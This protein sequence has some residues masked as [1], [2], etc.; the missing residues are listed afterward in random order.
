[1]GGKLTDNKY[2]GTDYPPG[3]KATDNC[4]TERLRGRPPRPF[5]RRSFR[6]WFKRKK[7]FLYG[8][9]Q[10]E[11]FGVFFQYTMVK[12]SFGRR[13]IDQ[14]GKINFRGATE[15]TA[16]Q[17]RASTKLIKRARST[18]VLL[19]YSVRIRALFRRYR[20][21]KRT[22]PGRLVPR[23]SYRVRRRLKYEKFRREVRRRKAAARWKRQ[24]KLREQAR[25]KELRKNNNI[26]LFR[27]F[28]SATRPYLQVYMKK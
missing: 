7:N 4:Y 27:R 5:R 21:F 18:N 25:G 11:K 24:Q 2:A 16:K 15:L 8:P 26:L 6:L 22:I 1:M 12:R 13:S 28:W 14:Y 20:F 17:H 10:K 9:L 23:K 19:P 3:N